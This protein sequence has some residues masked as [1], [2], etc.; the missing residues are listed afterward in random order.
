MQLRNLAFQIQIKAEKL[1]QEI[2]EARKQQSNDATE[3]LRKS[4][5]DLS[6]LWQIREVTETQLVEEQEFATA[7]KVSDRSIVLSKIFK[8]SE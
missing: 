7:L 2:V 6:R 5:K 8:C 3:K 4:K 1:Q